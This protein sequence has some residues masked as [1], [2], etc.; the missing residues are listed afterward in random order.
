MSVWAILTVVC[1]AAF[2]ASAFAAA[3]GRSTKF[4][5]AV[6]GVIA[7]ACGWMWWNH[8]RLEARLAD[9]ASLVAG[10]Q[11]HVDCQEPFF[12]ELFVTRRNGSVDARSDGTMDDVAH[13]ARGTCAAADSWPDD[14]TDDAFIAVHVLTH[15]A[16]HV[17]GERNEAATECW[18]TQHSAAVAEALGASRSQAERRA[19]WYFRSVYPRL[20]DTYRD[21]GCAGPRP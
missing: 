14:D 11:V 1:A 17:R 16:G 12:G 13:L 6:A 20:T 19:L 4:V 2:V 10:L 9:A 5:G 7:L 15:E 8:V 21:S 3:R 18:A